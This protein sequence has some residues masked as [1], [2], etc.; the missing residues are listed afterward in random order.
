MG[1]C[2]ILG[3]YFSRMP[4]EIWESL[5]LNQILG[6]YQFC[7]GIGSIKNKCENSGLSGDSIDAAGNFSRKE[8][9]ML[10]EGFNGQNL[11]YPDMGG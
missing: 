6:L 11:I 10:A 9:L 3:R 5:S 7:L 8:W 2:V 4:G 1:I